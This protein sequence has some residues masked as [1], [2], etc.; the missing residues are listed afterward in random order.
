MK[1]YIHAFIY[2]LIF[3]I[4]CQSI[5]FWVAFATDTDQECVVCSRMS[6]E[7]QMYVNFQVEMIWALRQVEEHKQL[8]SWLTK[9]WLFSYG[10]VKVWANFLNSLKSSINKTTESAVDTT[11][12]LALATAIVTKNAG[13]IVF[14][15]EWLWDLLIL[16]RQKQFLRDRNTLQEIDYSLDDLLRDVWMQGMLKQPVSS[17]IMSN[18]NSFIWKYRVMDEWDIKIFDTLQINGNTTYDEII[19]ALGDINSVMKN[20]FTVESMHVYKKNLAIFESKRWEEWAIQVKF[21]HQFLESLSNSYA[22]VKWVNW[23]KNCGG[24]LTTFASDVS[25][26]WSSVATE[27]TEA[28]KQIKE[29]SKKLAEAAKSVWKVAKNKYSKNATDLWLTDDQIEL[30]SDIY[31]INASKLTKQQGLSLSSILNGTAGKNI[32]NSTTISSDFWW[33]NSLYE[34]EETAKANNEYL[35]TDSL[36]DEDR[37]NF[38]LY[39]KQKTCMKR[40]NRKWISNDEKKKWKTKC[41]TLLWEN[42]IYLKDNVDWFLKYYVSNVS[43]VDLLTWTVLYLNKAMDWILGELETDKAIVMYSQNQSTTTYFVQVGGYIHD[44]VENVIWSKN[45]GSENIVNTLGKACK[46][47]CANKWWRCYK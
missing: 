32:K 5:L 16:F 36:T 9:K 27:F 21:N 8:Y 13:T 25:A 34:K 47:Q 44:S 6:D 29:S 38:S 37:D 7:M 35:T 45:G 22:C 41:T 18:I 12:S 39:M 2:T 20:F 4:S 30:L 33:K 46:T 10:T 3:I 17:D 43:S 42:S 23:V 40:L 31:G 1:K 14:T 26:I 15:P 24:S 19:F 28:W 11:R